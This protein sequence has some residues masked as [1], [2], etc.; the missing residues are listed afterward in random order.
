MGDLIY[1]QVAIDA[2]DKEY[3]CT[4]QSDDWDGLKTAMLIIENLPSA[5]PEHPTEIQDILTYLDEELHPIVALDD[6]N[7]Y[8]ELHDMISKL[9]AQ[10]EEVIPHRNYKY[11]SDYWCACGWHLG[12]KGEV[13]YCAD[14][15]RK[16]NWDG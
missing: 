4:D 9:S 12:K 8:S 11:L 1:R 3:R 6:W 10:P 2:I 7:I 14:C 13:K 5:Q 15:G 16:V